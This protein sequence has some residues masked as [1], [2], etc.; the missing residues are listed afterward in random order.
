MYLG[1][2]SELDSHSGLLFGDDSYHMLSHSYHPS[3]WRQLGSHSQLPR[4][5]IEILQLRRRPQHRGAI[6]WRLGTQGI[7]PMQMR[8]FN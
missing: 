5:L 8:G 6:A 7:Q 4:L 2:E 1:H 3:K